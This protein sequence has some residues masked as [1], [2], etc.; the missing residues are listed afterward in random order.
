MLRQAL[1]NVAFT[2]SKSKIF[3]ADVPETARTPY[4]RLDG[5]HWGRLLSGEVINRLCETRGKAPQTTALLNTP[6]ALLREIE[7]AVEDLDPSGELVIVLAG[8]WSDVLT[9]LSVNQPDGYQPQRQDPEDDQNREIARYNGHLVLRGPACDERQLYIVEP[10]AWG[11]LVRA[12][13]KSDRYSSRSNLS[14]LSELRRSWT[15]THS[16]SPRNPTRHRSYGS[17]RPAFRSGN[18]CPVGYVTS[19]GRRLR[20]SANEGG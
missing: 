5:G 7:E 8:D 16:T 11:R 14:V 6:E 9:D 2:I 3:L 4:P 19:I 1:T 10:E 15:Q 18:R 13:A 17:C 12:K 20:G